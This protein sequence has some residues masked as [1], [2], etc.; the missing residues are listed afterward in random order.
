MILLDYLAVFVLLAIVS[1][2]IGGFVQWLGLWDE[3]N[4]GACTSLALLSTVILW[5]VRQLWF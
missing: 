4:S 2:F 5:A 3:V 1:N